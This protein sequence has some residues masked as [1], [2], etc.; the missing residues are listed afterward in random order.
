MNVI[1]RRIAASAALLAAPA[2]I[3]LGAASSANAETWDNNP[4]ITSPDHRGPN[5]NSPSTRATPW[6]P[7]YGRGFIFVG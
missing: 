3:A 6:Q 2:L 5:F 4:A 7:I 1:T